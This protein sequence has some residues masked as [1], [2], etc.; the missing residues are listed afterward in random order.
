MLP[1]SLGKVYEDLT[2]EPDDRADALLA[3]KGRP[4]AMMRMIT[5]CV[6]QRANISIAVALQAIAVVLGF[7][8]G[9][10][11]H[12]LFRPAAPDNPLSRTLRGALGHR[13]SGIAAPAQAF[14][15]SRLFFDTEGSK[16]DSLQQKNGASQ[17]AM[18]KDAPYRLHEQVQ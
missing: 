1:D 4:T 6:R 15:I 18:T 11:S 8:A 17:I 9:C 10:L 3:T 12:L 2:G 5:A 16:R 7:P 14:N 13:D